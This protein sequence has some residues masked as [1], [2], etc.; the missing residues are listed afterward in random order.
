MVW[1]YP[2][3]QGC[4]F[5]LAGSVLV[6]SFSAHQYLGPSQVL[7]LDEAVEMFGE[8]IKRKMEALESVGALNFRRLDDF[9][10]KLDRDTAVRITKLLHGKNCF[11][12][13][14]SFDAFLDAFWAA[15]EALESRG[16]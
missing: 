4:E 16:Y 5:C 8:D 13:W 15:I 6:Q 14:E 7:V 12:G 10:F 9:G 11:R 1:K 2:L 3:G